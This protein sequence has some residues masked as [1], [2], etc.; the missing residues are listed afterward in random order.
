[1]HRWPIV[2]ATFF[3]IVGGAHAQEPKAPAADGAKIVLDNERVRVSEIT[4]KPGAKMRIGSAPE[5]FLYALTEATLAF[6]P[7]GK[8]GYE[9]M[10]NVGEAS[11]L[12]TSLPEAENV[13]EKELRA[14]IVEMKQP[15]RPV[16]V[17]AAARGRSKARAA[18]SGGGKA[19]AV[20][21][22]ARKAGAK[23]ATLPT[24]KI[25]TKVAGQPAK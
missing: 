18:R 10:L 8:A 23:S 15:A 19:A 6:L 20:K 1:M 17:R 11:L 13:G 16:A 3:A 4:V 9:V 22:T 21:A 7:P 14:I 5:Q 12:P 2:A 24:S 25:K